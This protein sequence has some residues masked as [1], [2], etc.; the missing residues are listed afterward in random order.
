MN[1]KPIQMSKQQAFNRVKRVIENP[2]N[3]AI[4]LPAIGNMV[5]NYENIYGQSNLSNR[6]ILLKTKLIKQL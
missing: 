3:E 5:R 4:H 6:L 1:I 2:N